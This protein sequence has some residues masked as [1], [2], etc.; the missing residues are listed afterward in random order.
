MI[1][2]VSWHAD[3]SGEPVVTFRK[4]A[5]REPAGFFGHS[6]LVESIRDTK[7]Q[8]CRVWEM[9]DKDFYLLYDSTAPRKKEEE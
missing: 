3:G 1:V 2:I 6:Q 9:T 5:Y 4:I 7:H 8:E